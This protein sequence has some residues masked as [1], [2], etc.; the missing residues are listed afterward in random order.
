M[1]KK[2]FKSYHFESASVGL[3]KAIRIDSLT[4]EKFFFTLKS[5]PVEH[6]LQVERILFILLLCIG[7][8]PSG[9]I[10]LTFRRNEVLAAVAQVIEIEFFDSPTQQNCF[11]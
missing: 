6:Q 2:Y 8:E 7:H 1:K 9:R 4:K 3:K 11:A 5:E 10:I